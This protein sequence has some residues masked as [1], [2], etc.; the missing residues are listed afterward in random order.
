MSSKPPTMKFTYLTLITS[1]LIACQAEPQ[2]VS[3]ASNAATPEQ[4]SEP[5]AMKKPHV[6]EAHG[7]QRVDNY[8]WLRDDTRSD[9]DVLAYLEAENAWTEHQL[10]DS[11]VLQETLYD[12]MISRLTPED[13]SVPVRDGD[14]WY[15]SRFQPDQDFAV[16][17]RRAGNLEAAEEILIDGN[18]RAEGY[19]YYSLANLT[20][21]DDGR[22]IAVAEDFMGRRIHEIRILDTD[23]GQFLPEILSEAAPDLAWSA[24]G[25]YLFYLK[26]DP[27]TLLA[28][29][30][31]RHK[32]GKAPAED[33]I[34]YEERDETF[35]TSLYRSRSGT[36][37]ALMHSETNT[38]EVQ[39]MRADSPTGA[40]QPVIPRE[41]NHEYSVED[42][43]GT[44]YILTN[45]QAKNF[46]VIA[47]N[48][49]SASDKSKWT[50]VIPTTPGQLITDITALRDWLVLETLQDGERRIWAQRRLSGERMSIDSDEPA[51][52]YWGSDN[53]ST[54]T[55]I[56]RY[57]QTSLTRP[58]QTWEVDL[59]TGTRQLLKETKVPGAYDTTQYVAKKIDLP[60]RDGT[61]VP[62]TLAYHRN[63]P[64]DGSAPG[65][66]YG[67]GSYGSS[68]LP[69]FN[70]ALISLLNR[71]FVYAI[72][73]I[74]GGQ[75]R[76]RE[77]YEAGKMMNKIN[78]F[79]DF[80]DV[81]DALQNQAIID[82]KRTNAR[83]GSAG[84]LLMGAVLNM[85][86]SLYHGVIAA[87]PFVDVIT[88]MSDP[89]IPL[90]TGEWNEWGD[91]RE[92]AAYD[93]MLSYSPYDQVSAQDYPNLL[94]TT[95][96]HDSQVQYFEPAKW[97]AKLREY[98]TDQN[99]LMLYT[100][101]SAG[102]S[103]ASGRLKQFEDYAREFAFLISLSEGQDAPQ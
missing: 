7:E 41:I 77:W 73:H 49:E 56:F 79:T 16:Y 34:V 43:D 38:T 26:Q 6:L 44:L 46:R 39:L 53:V 68:T 21:S 3:D 23:S 19:D 65:L 61:L 80:I 35:Y 30:V 2:A 97:V 24:D 81:T 58:I 14:Y 27:Q 62:V 20:P 92:K 100:D 52:T 75:E 29:Y 91:P 74:R 90:T 72:A 64:L 31:M 25:Q 76:G 70:P 84:G 82:P 37:L 88:T 4:P 102:H 94:V 17:A 83:G 12:E 63:T 54:D 40:F 67:Y 1:V 5:V 9:P 50:E 36:W 69:Y 101:M 51:T 95:G 42:V 87:V 28:K 15:Y 93:Y 78:T 89:S 47:T 98:R 60:A 55:S 22:F 13:T 18:G 59:D 57:V 11:K 86:P 99:T 71:G 96:L 32:L 45:W 10:R 8:Y 33:E 85:A 103:G 66:V 48:H